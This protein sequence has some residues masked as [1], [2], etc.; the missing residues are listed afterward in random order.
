METFRGAQKRKLMVTGGGEKGARRDSRKHLRHFRKLACF[1]FPSEHE[2]HCSKS[3]ER[4]MDMKAKTA[5]KENPY[6]DWKRGAKIPPG[7]SPL[8]TI[9]EVANERFFGLW[10][11]L[12]RA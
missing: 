12:F 4:L 2:W 8:I 5:K 10:N 6:G 3:D 9:D 7:I 1:L 11:S